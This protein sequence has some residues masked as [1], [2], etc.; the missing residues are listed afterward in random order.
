[1]SVSYE[2]AGIEPRGDRRTARGPLI[3]EARAGDLQLVID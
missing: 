2:R 3:Q 1:M